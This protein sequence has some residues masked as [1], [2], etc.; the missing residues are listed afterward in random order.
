VKSRRRAEDV[1]S[2]RREVRGRGKE[3]KRVEEK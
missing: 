3:E 1:K 2:R